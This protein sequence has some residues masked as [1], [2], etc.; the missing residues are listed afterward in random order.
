[1]MERITLGLVGLLVGDLE[2]YQLLQ[3][4]LGDSIRSVPNFS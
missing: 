3:R 1:M 2:E 4:L